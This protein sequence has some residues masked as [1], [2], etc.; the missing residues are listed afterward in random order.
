MTHIQLL[1]WPKTQGLRNTW[2]KSSGSEKLLITGFSVFGVLFWFG[3]SALLY[4]FIRTFYGIEI[5]GPIVL[6]KLMELLMLS[7]F[8]LLCF[9]NVVTALSNYYLSEDLELLLS[10]PISRVNF[11]IARLID[12][13]AQSSWMAIFLGGPILISYGI[14]Y[15]AGPMYY[16]VTAATLVAFVLIP[17]SLGVLIASILVSVFPARKIREALVL[18]G[19][20][21]LIFIFI[22]IRLLRPE[23]LANADNFESVAAYMAELQTPVPNLLPPKWAS[24]SLMAALLSRPFP[25]VEF[26]M[27]ITGAGAITGI[28]RWITNALYDGGRSKA[29]EA[30]TARLAKSHGLDFLLKIWTK[31]LT[32]MAKNIVIKDVKTFVRDPS[33]WTQLF[34]VG[35][36]VAIAIISVANLPVDSFRGPYMKPWLNALSFLILALVGFVMAALAARFQFS[37]VSMEGRGFWIVRTGPIDAETFLWAKAWPGIVPMIIIGE[38]LA[39]SS[40]TILDS[41]SAM[42]WIGIGT[43]AFLALG[44]SGLAVGM[45]ALYPDFKSDNASKLAASPAGMLFMVMAL[46]LVFCV[47]A[48]EAAPVYYLITSQVQKATLTTNQLIITIVCLASAASIC[49]IAAILPIKIGAR[50]LWRRELPNG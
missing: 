2:K 31:P 24:N 32:P 44:L 16:L 33:Q 3:L 30:R 37:A 13:I 1:L 6:D 36:I 38:V 5:V 46:A 4:Y 48:L 45:G 29:Q 12:T 40:I 19:I 23:Q 26:S 49:I 17:A 14:V 25:W 47:L 43:A 8:G 42:L 35:S 15:G 34:L 9:S 7:L 10:L 20:L 11:H 41:Q 27:L 22:L 21:S 39:I 50:T 28:S 18:V